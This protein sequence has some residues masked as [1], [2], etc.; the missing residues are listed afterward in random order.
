VQ[1]ANV[2]EVCSLVSTAAVY[3]CAYLYL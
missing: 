2:S 3:G 1:H